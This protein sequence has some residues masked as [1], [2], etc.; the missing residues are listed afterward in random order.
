[1]DP[2]YISD[3]PFIS[4]PEPLKDIVTDFENVD[5]ISAPEIYETEPFFSDSEKNQKNKKYNISIIVFFIIILFILFFLI[6]LS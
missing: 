3:S 1:M 2:F 4:H 6:L 5:Y